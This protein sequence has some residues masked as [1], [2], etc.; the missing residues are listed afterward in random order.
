VIGNSPIFIEAGWMGDNWSNKQ[1]GPINRTYNGP[2]AG[3][4]FRILYP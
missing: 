3:L 4:G 1:N 2:F